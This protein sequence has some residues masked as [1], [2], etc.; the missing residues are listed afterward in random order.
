MGLPLL[1]Q[2]SASQ[3]QI[4]QQESMAPPD[5]LQKLANNGF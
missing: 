1:I 5:S 3:L 4:H 2:A